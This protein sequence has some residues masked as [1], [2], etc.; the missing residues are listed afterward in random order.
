MKACE[1]ITLLQSEVDAFGDRDVVVFCPE[2]SGDHG[3]DPVPV[4]GL[5]WYGDEAKDLRA[6]FI[7]CS[8]CYEESISD[9]AWDDAMSEIAA[10]QPTSEDYEVP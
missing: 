2:H 10:E 6:T 8:F 4:A 7:E 5:G 9:K 1:L 3:H